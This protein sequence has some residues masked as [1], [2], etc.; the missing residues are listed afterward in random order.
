MRLFI[1]IFLLFFGIQSFASQDSQS[2]FD[3][4]E[5]PL[6]FDNLI[7]VTSDSNFSNITSETSFDPDD[8]KIYSSIFFIHRNRHCKSPYI[9]RSERAVCEI[10]DPRPLNQTQSES[11]PKSY[12][13][14]SHECITIIPFS[15]RRLV[16]QKKETDLLDDGYDADD[17]TDF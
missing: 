15:L 4:E 2:E 14:A 12:Q 9:M 10:D 1:S 7:D 8:I 13:Y 17:E 6:I 16:F 5:L 11:K 3:L